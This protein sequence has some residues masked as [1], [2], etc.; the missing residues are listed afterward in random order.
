MGIFFSSG[1]M[2]LG[3]NGHMV[4]EPNTNFGF[5]RHTVYPGLARRLHGLSL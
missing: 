1:Q 3:L 4:D 2:M 5:P